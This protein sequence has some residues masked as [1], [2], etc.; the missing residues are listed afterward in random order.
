MI[1]ETVKPIL[2]SSLN[3][4]APVESLFQARDIFEVILVS[5]QKAGN[6]PRLS[7][8]SYQE[9]KWAQSLLDEN[10]IVE[11]IS[12]RSLIGCTDL[13]L[14][15]AKQEDILQARRLFEI[16]LNALS[17]EDTSSQ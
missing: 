17:L 2:E 4:N 15:S 16:L 5:G 10:G 6:L 14:K 1:P 13:L 9:L 3:P 7:F 8:S 11:Q 12:F